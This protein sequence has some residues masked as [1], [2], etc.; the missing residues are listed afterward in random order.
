MRKRSV[1]SIKDSLINKSREAM[2]AAVQIYN[3][4]SI[5]FK[6]ENYIVLATISWTYL[7]HAYYREIKVDYR[8][9]NSKK[10]R[11]NTC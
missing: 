11:E 1:K 10:A 8:Y 4:P 5:S 2:I 6:T 3:N 7:L 9:K